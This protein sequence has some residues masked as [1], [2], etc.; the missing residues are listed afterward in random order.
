MTLELLASGTSKSREEEA[1]SGLPGVHSIH[2]HLATVPRVLFC[3][4][5]A[6]DWLAAWSW[7]GHTATFCLCFLAV[8]W[9]GWLWHGSQGLTRDA[10]W[11]VYDTF[12][13]LP[14]GPCVTLARLQPLLPRAS[15]WLTRDLKGTLP[16]QP[17]FCRAPRFLV[18]KPPWLQNP[19]LHCTYLIVTFTFWLPW[20]LGIT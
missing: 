20:V 11:S 4:Y 1:A 16:F 15:P 13:S 6:H 9:P 17:Q 18:P 19:T 7:E 2:S 14:V 5:S 12:R 8:R 10:G 3:P